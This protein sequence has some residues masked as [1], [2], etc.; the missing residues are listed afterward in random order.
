[1]A[2]EH[3]SPT[4]GIGGPRDYINRGTVLLERSR[5]EGTI[6]QLTVVEGQ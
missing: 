1:M 2:V 3:T 6:S 5:N 4:N